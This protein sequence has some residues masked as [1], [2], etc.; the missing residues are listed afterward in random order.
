[1]GTHRGRASQEDRTGKI[2]PEQ[3]GHISGAI[4]TNLWKYLRGMDLAVAQVL[5]EKPYL[6]GRALPN[7]LLL[8]KLEEEAV[9]LIPYNDWKVFYR[10]FFNIDINPLAIAVPHYELA[11]L[12]FERIIFMA[13]GI[14]PNRTYEAY[15]RSGIP[16]RRFTEDLDKVL[17]WDKEERDPRKGSYAIRVRD[18]ME[19]DEVLKGL[20]ANDIKERGIKTET[21]SE[22]LIHGLKVWSE[23]KTHLDANSITNC[24]G[25]RYRDGNVPHVDWSGPAGEVGVGFYVPGI[26]RDILRS[27]EV[28]SL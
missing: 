14:T 16:C 5:I 12:D 17:D 22:C 9:K 23:S 2:T 4:Q 25:S 21:L 26:S 8:E 24:T 28:V 1:M 13:Y 11:R 19:S 10:D 3:F 6:V 27:R 20:L 7:S 15:Q 18:C